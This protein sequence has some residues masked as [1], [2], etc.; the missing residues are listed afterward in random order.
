MQGASRGFRDY[1]DESGLA[2]QLQDAG[3]HTAMISP[4]GQRH[5]AHHFY[6]GFNEIHNT[7]KGGLESAED[8]MPI[9]TRWLEPDISP[10]C[11]LLS[12]ESLSVRSG[13]G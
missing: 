3:L 10:L 13:T 12:S 6:A 8:V 1:F 4:F 5:A 9:A 2:R 11:T 7:G